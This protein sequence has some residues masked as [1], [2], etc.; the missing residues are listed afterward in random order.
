MRSI[1][2]DA[3]GG[4][5][6]DSRLALALAAVVALAVVTTGQLG[7]VIGAGAALC[8][9]GTGLILA[10][11]GRL[12]APGTRW[13][14]CLLFAATF[15]SMADMIG[16]VAAPKI[17]SAAGFYLP[18]TAVNCA[19]AASWGAFEEGAT[20]G[21]VLS[22]A[23]K[24]GVFCLAALTIVGCARELLGAGTLFGAALCAGFQPVRVIALAPGGFLI[25]GMALALACLIARR[26]A[27]KGGGK[28]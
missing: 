26:R 2:D 13:F 27:A 4:A 23:V 15:A 18:L 5:P 16:G 21:R 3:R 19:L 25:G 6:M 9:I 10:G 12:I 24:K 28:V 20:P 14:V 8:V 17:A 1:F 7:L 22:G 11:L